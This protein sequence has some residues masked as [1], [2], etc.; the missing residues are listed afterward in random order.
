MA[1]NL[2]SATLLAFDIDGTLT[3]A[4]TWWGGPELGWLQRY[5][6]RDGEALLRLRDRMPV[7]PLSRN[8]TKAARVRME[9]LGFDT[10]WLGT[11]DKI[12]S[13]WEICDA[14]D[15][16]PAGV[17]HVG[18]GPDDATVFKE[19]GFGLAVAD[20]H[21]EALAAAALV[22]DATGGQRVIEEI[23]LRIGGHR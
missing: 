14:F 4:T 9:A 12:E 21:P 18:D 2:A 16:Q 6:V 22:L 13:L 10:R 20:A 5:S 19:I 15:V 17:C 7:V 1:L 3:D 8:K 23:E 11:S